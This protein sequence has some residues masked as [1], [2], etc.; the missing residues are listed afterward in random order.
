MFHAKPGGR[1]DLRATL[2]AELMAQQDSGACPGGLTGGSGASNAWDALCPL[3]HAGYGS[4]EVGINF[5]KPNLGSD[6]GE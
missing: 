5:H 2:R 3:L 4:Y 1:Q 6:K